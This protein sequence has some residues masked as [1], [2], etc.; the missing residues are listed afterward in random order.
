M[1]YAYVSKYVEIQW[2]WVTVG[3]DVTYTLYTRQ[4]YIIWNFLMIAC[5]AFVIRQSSKYV[6]P[7][8]E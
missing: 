6:Y 3:L 7:K 4:V 1:L 8:S 5:I 2:L